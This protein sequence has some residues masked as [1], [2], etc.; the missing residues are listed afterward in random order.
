M[1]VD[2]A[3]EDIFVDTGCLQKVLARERPLGCIEEGDEQR[4]FTLCQ[5]DRLAP[6]IGQAPAAPV[7]QPAAEPAATFLGIARRRS[8][9][10]IRAKSSRSPNGLVM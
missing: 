5:A 7:E 9:A 10:R 2:A 8:T 1:H 3:V 4:I 6:R